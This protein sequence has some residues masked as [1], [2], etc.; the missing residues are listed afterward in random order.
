[1]RNRYLDS[2]VFYISPWVGNWNLFAVLHGVRKRE[3]VLEVAVTTLAASFEDT[4]ASWKKIISR[5]SRR[6]KLHKL[7]I[8]HWLKALI[9]KALEVVLNKKLVNWFKNMAK[10]TWQRE[11]YQMRILWRLTR[12]LIQWLEFIAFALHM[13]SLIDLFGYHQ[14]SLVPWFHAWVFWVHFGVKLI[15]HSP[16]EYVLKVYFLMED[17]VNIFEARKGGG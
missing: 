17:A 11:P 5:N 2:I 15:D 7:K 9:A 4:R 6:Y 1:M 12:C 13:R 3:G 8:V 14:I 10:D 16:V